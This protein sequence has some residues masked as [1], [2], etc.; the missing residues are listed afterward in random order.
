MSLAWASPQSRLNGKEDMDFK[1]E[2]LIMREIFEIWHDV[3]KKYK[4]TGDNKLLIWPS[5]TSRFRPGV[6]NQ[7]VKKWRNK[8]ITAICTLIDKQHFK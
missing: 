2:N 5:N 7:T 8:G 1:E 6:L 3:V 4:L